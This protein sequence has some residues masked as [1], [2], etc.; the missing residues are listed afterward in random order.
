MKEL[1]LGGLAGLALGIA[2]QRLHLHRRDEFRCALGLL[3]PSLLRKLLVA[4]GLGTLLTALLM[5]LAVIDVD[6]VAVPLLDGGTVIGGVLFGAVLGWS[7]LAP[8]TSGVVL[9]AD[10]FWEGLCAVAG[11]VAG[12]ALLPYV[13]GVFPALRSWL[14]AEGSTW[15]QV[16]LDE[17][18]L[19]AGGFLGQGCIGLVI[20]AAGLCI[21]RAREDPPQEESAPVEEVS[22]EPQDVQE[23]TF[24]AILPGEEPVV[25]DTNEEGEQQEETEPDT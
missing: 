20:A 6:T 4:L 7:G 8:A 23:E 24:V 13:E 17:P 10:R 14:S 3:A 12:A 21:R 22:A 5:W 18:Y 19:F 15:F 1:I 25:V 9:G 16:T 11:C 2:A